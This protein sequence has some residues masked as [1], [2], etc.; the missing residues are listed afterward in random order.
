MKTERATGAL[1]PLTIGSWKKL[2]QS[3]KADEPGTNWLGRPVKCPGITLVSVWSTV[4][5]QTTYH[6]TALAAARPGEPVEP[7]DE[8][9]QWLVA[10]FGL[11]SDTFHEVVRG[12]LND[13]PLIDVWLPKTP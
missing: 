8:L 9:W 4:F 3:K 10:Q 1:R 2:T 11:P 13:E 6:L 12:P 7:T 5:D